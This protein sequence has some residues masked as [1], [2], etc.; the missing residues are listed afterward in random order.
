V[1]LADHQDTGRKVAIKIIKKP[2]SKNNL[3]STSKSIGK[4]LSCVFFSNPHIL[5]L[6]EVCIRLEALGDELLDIFRSSATK[7]TRI[8]A[9]ICR[10][11]ST[12]LPKPVTEF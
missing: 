2:I 10:P 6:I 5:R 11:K 8:F 4:S 12:Q 1:K 9:L 7:A 3:I